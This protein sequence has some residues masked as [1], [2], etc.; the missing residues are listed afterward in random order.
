[1]FYYFN[2]EMK[3]YE[4]PF[5]PD[6]I[7]NNNSWEDIQRAAQEGIAADIW[8]VG[9]RKEITINGTVGGITYSDKKVYAYILGFNHNS[10]LE[11]NNTIHFGVGFNALENGSDIAFCNPD[12]YGSSGSSGTFRMNLS[13]TNNGGWADSYMRNYIIPSFINAMSSDLQNVLKVV[14]KYTDNS[15]TSPHDEESFVTATQDKVFLL[16]EYEVFG[17]ASYANPYE[18]FKQ[19]QYDF[20]NAYGSKIKMRDY[21]DNAMADW[22]MRSPSKSGSTKFLYSSAGSLD[23]KDSNYSE[24]FAPAFVVG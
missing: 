17:N 4:K 1:M 9:D 11:G 20:Y 13:T 14:T 10:I 23:R 24:G 3:Y 2:A 22:W 6:P 16:S 8:N 21:M 5:A 15:F 12:N 18:R 7:L 19:A